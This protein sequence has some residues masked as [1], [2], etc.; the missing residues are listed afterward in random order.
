ML[1]VLERSLAMP[2]ACAPERSSMH[3]DHMIRIPSQ[4]S[5]SSMSFQALKPH[6]YNHMQPLSHDGISPRKS[7]CICDMF[8]L[9]CQVTSA[10]VDRPSGSDRP[11]RCACCWRGKCGAHCD[12]SCQSTV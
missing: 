12:H 8:E 9:N 10:A 5:E 4:W 11:H 1:P 7:C 3:H 2:Q 6:H